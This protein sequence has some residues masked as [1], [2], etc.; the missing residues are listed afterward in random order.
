MPLYVQVRHDR[1]QL[2]YGAAVSVVIF[3]LCFIFALV[4]QQ[5][6]MRRDLDGSTNL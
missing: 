3:M 5:F 1:F 6:V 2:G 4:Y